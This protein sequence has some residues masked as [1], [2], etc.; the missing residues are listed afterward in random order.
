MKRREKIKRTRK[1]TVRFSEA[2]FDKVMHSFRTTTKRKLSEYIRYV[3]LEKPVTVYT[4]DQSLDDMLALFVS[5]KNELSAIG[6]NYN[7]SVKK[8]HTMDRIPEIKSWTE[9]SEKQ[10]EL[11]MNKVTEINLKIAQLSDK[12]L[13]E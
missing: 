11:F 3:L 13:Q 5:L 10:Q 8:L 9:I 2:E 7:Q 6:N 1:I 4:R 12:W